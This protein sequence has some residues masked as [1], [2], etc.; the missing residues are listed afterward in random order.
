MRAGQQRAP[1]GAAVV[2]AVHAAAALVLV[3][4]R[5]AHS[6]APRVAQASALARHAQRRPAARAPG[7]AA[8]GAHPALAQRAAAVGAGVAQRAAAGV[9]VA[10]RRAWRGVAQ[11][12]VDE[13]DGWRVVWSALDG[14]RTPEGGSRPASVVAGKLSRA[15]PSW[16]GVRPPRSNVRE[17]RLSRR[18][19]QLQAQSSRSATRRGVVHGGRHA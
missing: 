12:I 13:A 11:K 14:M 4:P 9:H 10:Q 19:I 15:A 16:F 18:L 2:A 8:C 7:V 5:V 6:C 17:G 3:R 1:T